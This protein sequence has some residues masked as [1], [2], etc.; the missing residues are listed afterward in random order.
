M[1]LRSVELFAG[2]GGL[3]LGLD[4]AG[5][6]HDAIVE[7]DHD[8]CSTLRQNRIEKVRPICDWPEV[9]EGDVR[10]FDFSCVSGIDLITGGPPCQPFSLGGKHRA[11]LDDRDMFPAAINA[12]R[13]AAPRAFIF[14]NVK[15]L[16]RSTFANYLS[17][18][19][20]Q[21]EF[22]NLVARKAE[23]WLDHLARLEQHKTKG[24]ESEYHVVHRVL[25]AAD[26]GVPQRRERVFIV[27]LRKDVGREFSFPK[28]THSY[29]ALLFSQWVS[30]EYWDINRVSKKDR[31]RFPEA[32]RGKIASL[33]DIYPSLLPHPWRTVRE[34]IADLADPEKTPPSKLPQAHVFQPGARSYVGH[35]GSPLDEPAKALKAGD[36]GVPG[37]E[38]MLRRSDGGVRYFT[39]R[40]SAR[41]QTFPDS[42]IFIGSWTETMR[43]LGNAVPV[44]LAACVAS[45]VS[46]K[47]RVNN[48]PPANGE[49]KKTA[50]Q[51]RRPS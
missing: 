46:D 41:I 49:G 28:P 40:E 17:Y 22:P 21:L 39:V 32:L 36:H 19:L 51:R 43:Q 5:V 31:P 26:Y 34:A 44:R 30:G 14:E 3:A 35:T 42:Y 48:T 12:I 16:T 20:L 9:I 10:N 8:A 2:A 38:N 24:G 29:E 11:F 33:S 13:V 6:V 1:T 25:D 23:E 27:G 4:A 47:L 18:V 50:G 45:A 15:G 37:G 7:W